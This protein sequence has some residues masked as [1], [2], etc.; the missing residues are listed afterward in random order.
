[1]CRTYYRNTDWLIK[2]NPNYIQNRKIGLTSTMIR[3][4]SRNTTGVHEYGVSIIYWLV[5][6]G[7]VVHHLL[8][9]MHP[10]VGGVGGL[11]C[12]S[13]VVTIADHR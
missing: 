6:L 4:K 13:S 12:Y 2:H 5:S 10:G 8:L 1:M 11:Y 9:V 3:P 7:D